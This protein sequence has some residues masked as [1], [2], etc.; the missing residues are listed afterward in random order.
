MFGGQ[1]EYYG[2]G[3]FANKYLYNGK[4]LQNDQLGATKLNWYDFHARMYMADLGRTTTQDPMLEKFYGLSPYSMFANNPLRFTDPTG[5]EIEEG[6]KKLWEKQKGSVTKQRD[7]LQSKSDGL[8]AKAEKKGWSADKLAKKQGNLGE[9][10]SSLNTS[11]ETMGTLEASDQVYSLS[12]AAEGSNG[13][14]TL[15]PKTNVINIS[16][17][18]TANF[19]HETTHAGQFETGDVAF[20]KQSGVSLAQ[21]VFDEVAAYK[22]QFAYSPSSVSGLTS[23]SVAN[24]FGSIT[25][26]WVQGLGGGSLYVPLG[27]PNYIPGVSANTGVSP[28]NINSTKSDFIKAYPNAAIMKSLPTNYIL[29]NSPFTYY[30]K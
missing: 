1:Q 18:N 9:R 21:D 7:R 15:D 8:V 24:S 13:G 23:T 5:M 2:D 17:G 20:N 11:L 10:I 16:F 26:S 30:K 28:L 4:E 27:H 6:S 19:V 29:K 14:L 22:A 3:V 12:R 25:A